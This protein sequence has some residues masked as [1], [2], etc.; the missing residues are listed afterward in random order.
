M[1]SS[2]SSFLAM[3]GYGLYVWGSLGMCALTMGLEMWLL[4]A[5]RRAL[6]R[7]SG[8]A[9]GLAGADQTSAGISA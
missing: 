9:S 6:D 7:Q 2:L 8:P 1:T 5:R 4:R 3:G